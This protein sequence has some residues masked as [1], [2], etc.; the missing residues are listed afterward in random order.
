MHQDGTWYRGGPWSKPHFERDG[1]PAP[2]PQKGAK[3]PPRFTAHFHCGQTVGRIKIPL[4]IE[5]GLSLDDI[6]LD[7][8]P[9][10]PPQK[11]A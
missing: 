4:G 3:P 6:V 5:V 7:G 11:G 2:L 10:L 8:N 9:T 1:D